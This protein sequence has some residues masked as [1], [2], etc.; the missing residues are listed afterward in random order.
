MRVSR[1]LISVSCLFVFSTALVLA[2]EP[3]PKADGNTPD[4]ASTKTPKAK[5][6]PKRKGPQGPFLVQPYLQL[7]HTQ[8]AGK[9]VLLW[10][11]PDADAAWTV[12]YRAGAGR[13]WQAAKAPSIS[14]VA[15]AGIEPHRVYHLALT[16]LQPGE[17]FSYRVSKEGASSSKSDARAPKAADQP[18]RFVVFGD[19]GADT[20]EETAI[21]YRTFLSK[22]DF[23]MITG[24]I[25]YDKGLRFRIPREV[26]ADLQR[27]QRVAVGRCAALAF[28]PLCRRSRK[29]RHRIPRPGEDARR[30]GLFLLLAPAAERPDR[31]GGGPAGR[32]GPRPG[33]EPES[34]PR[35]RR[36]GLPA[37]GQFLVRLRQ[38]PLDGPRRQPHRRLDRPRAAAVGRARPGRGQGS[39][40]AVRQLPPARLQF[41]QRPTSTSSTC[42][43]SPRS[44]EAGKVDVVFSG[45]VHNYQR[46]YPLTVRPVSGQ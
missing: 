5:A 16:G 18:H 44:F 4:G 22:P 13:P 27:R 23:V 25:V 15:V 21:A 40:L 36:Q 17:A 8:A 3:T 20:P 7:G 45:H 9:L 33:A 28:D 29:P 12:E 2:Q 32:A 34:I 19:C 10:H 6:K 31:Q 11:A 42:G 35:R 24:D 26:L 41:V 30:P 46:T 1:L 43:F 39:D 38:R 37:D 14:R